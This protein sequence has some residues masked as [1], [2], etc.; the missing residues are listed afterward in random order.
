[1]VVIRHPIPN[2]RPIQ[3]TPVP[4][5][6]YLLTRSRET[7]KAPPPAGAFFGTRSSECNADDHD[8]ASMRKPIP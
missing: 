7:G 2:G 6:A 1:M 4:D 5:M 3:P 8:R